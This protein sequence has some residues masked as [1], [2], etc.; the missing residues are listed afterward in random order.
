ML[1]M[2]LYVLIVGLVA[3]LLFLVAS[4]I[5]GRSEELGP[6]P[7]GTTV[8]VLPASGIS[9]CDVRAVRFQQ[10]F[11]GYKAGEVDW[12]LARLAARIDELEGQLARATAG[13]AAT[14]QP[15]TAEAPQPRRVVP[16]EPNGEVP[17]PQV[18]GSE[19]AA[20]S[21][22]TATP[23]AGDEPGAR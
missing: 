10:V 21:V 2:L 9:G 19:S 11:R 3:A 12:A 14:G 16:G 13:E 23:P 7:E 17:V 8:T 1:T 20:P 15:G 6:L 18:L 22:P 4:A 5:F